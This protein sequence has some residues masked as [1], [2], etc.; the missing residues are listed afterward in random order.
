MNSTRLVCSP[1]LSRSWVAQRPRRPSPSLRRRSFR[2]VAR[3]AR[4]LCLR[5][6]SELPSRVRWGALS[7]L[8][9]K[10]FKQIGIE[11]MMLLGMLAASG[12][13]NLFWF[14]GMRVSRE[15]RESVDGLILGYT[16][17]SCFLPAKHHRLVTLAT[18]IN[19][20]ITRTNR[21]MMVI[22]MIGTIPSPVPVEW[23]KY[24]H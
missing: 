22:A 15:F 6:R 18:T 19:A 23:I 7:L 21:T 13:V 12:E 17:V 11:S 3:S 24:F 1:L 4:V 8:Q 5:G 9:R 14:N 20:T 10:I 2:C 16:D